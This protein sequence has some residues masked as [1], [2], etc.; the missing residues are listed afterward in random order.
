MNNGIFGF[1][2]Q[3]YGST[4]IEVKEFDTSGSYAIPNGAKLVVGEVAVVVDET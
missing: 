1:Q 3:N 4:V 2:N